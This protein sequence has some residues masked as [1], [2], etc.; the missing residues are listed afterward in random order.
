M[1]IL[2][3]THYFWPESFRINDL[4][5][6][7]KDLGHDVT[8]V[9]G[10]PNYPA[11]SLF[12]GY[13]WRGPYREEYLDAPVRRM[14]VLTRGPNRGARLVLNY[15]SFVLSGVILLPFLARGRY[16]ITFV[17]AP[18][19]ITQCLPA[20]WLRWLRGTPVVFWVQDLWPDTLVSTGAVRSERI[21]RAVGWLSR[22]IY[23]HC[24]LVLPSSE[25]FLGPIRRVCPEVKDL[26]VLPNWA[27]AFYRP[28][29]VDSD[30]PERRELP[31][32]FTII[33]AGNLGSAQSLGTVL[34]AADILRSED[35][36]WVFIGDGN[37]RALLEAAVLERRLGG[38]VRF[39][40]WKPG[41][42]MPRY[43]NCAD[44]LL[45]SLRRDASFAVTV[46]AK[47]QSSLAI[48][49]PIL[50]ALE[51]EGARVVRESGAGVVV[52]QESGEAL[53]AGALSLLRA[54][55]S[56]REEMGRRGRDYAMQH[57]DR[58]TLV[59]RLDVWLR[60]VVEER[61]EDTDSRR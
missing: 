51:G 58:D 54:G 44:A 36:H 31:A 11:G 48:G 28:A 34:D 18:S 35:V 53:A 8:I 24:D 25:G 4:V 14:P 23:R 52:E 40:G 38:R 42:A 55:T 19:P 7:W 17:Y 41:E 12:E 37:Q 45:V 32:G 60:A 10:L 30:A 61:R 43:L 5:R 20:I 29:S 1:K 50:A 57:F 2:V 46:P 47:L 22:W 6:A 49:R 13:S 21:L 33:F 56:A 39:L 16:D 15:L 3:V 59:A 9:T 26:R 27:D